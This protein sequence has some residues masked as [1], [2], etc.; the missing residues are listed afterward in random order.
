MIGPV[1]ILCG[2]E[3]GAAAVALWM[4]H[5]ALSGIL[6]IVGLICLGAAIDE[7]DEDL[8]SP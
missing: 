8:C 6:C 2:L 4:G 7:S 5:G 1:G 3:F